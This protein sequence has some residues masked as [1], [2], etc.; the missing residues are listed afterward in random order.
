MGMSEMR[1][2]LA[3]QIRDSHLPN[4]SKLLAEYRDRDDEEYLEMRRD[5][6]LRDAE[7]L[8]KVV[9][10]RNRKILAAIQEVREIRARSKTSSI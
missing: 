2:K 3:D 8:A 5:Q 4:V 10:E 1:G 7:R 6:M 9:G